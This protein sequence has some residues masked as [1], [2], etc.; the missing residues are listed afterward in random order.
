MTGLVSPNQTEPV[1]AEGV[2]KRI[3]MIPTF[4]KTYGKRIT[5]KAF[6]NSNPGLR[7]GNLGKRIS[8]LEGATP[9]GLRKISSSIFEP[10]VSK[11]ILGRH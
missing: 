6:A 1:P 9:S 5:L 3:E 10:R 11:Q 2:L 4:E 7:L 8:F